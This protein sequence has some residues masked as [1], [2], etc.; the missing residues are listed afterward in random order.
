MLRTGAFGEW[1]KEG[2]R[3]D[4]WHR[5]APRGLCTGASDP[6]NL[7]PQVVRQVC[8]GPVYS[9]DTDVKGDCDGPQGWLYCLLAPVSIFRAE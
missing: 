8:E 5:V 1:E 4:E 2:A 3:E 6:C 7:S 9:G